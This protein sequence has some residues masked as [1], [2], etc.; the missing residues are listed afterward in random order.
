MNAS[1]DPTLHVARAGE[2]AF[3]VSARPELTEL[4]GTWWWVRVDDAWYRMVRRAPNEVASFAGGQAWLEENLQ[5]PRDGQ[6][7][8]ERGPAWWASP[9]DP[10]V[11]DSDRGRF[12][13]YPS[14]SSA[15]D[16][17]EQFEDEPQWI[18]QYGTLAF[19]VP[20]DCDNTVVDVYTHIVQALAAQ[21]LAGHI[22][23]VD[24]SELN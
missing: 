19:Q 11:I 13:C 1:V 18:V 6:M 7:V 8:W 2:R 20:L 15:S 4:R 5:L 17:E 3:V 21:R 9:A 16:E 22:A 10:L 23:S 14:E 12:S 24:T